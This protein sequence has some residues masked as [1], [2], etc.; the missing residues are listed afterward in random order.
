MLSGED[1]LNAFQLKPGRFPFVL[2]VCAGLEESQL[3]VAELDRL[4]LP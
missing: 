4:R 1:H 3:A 2:F